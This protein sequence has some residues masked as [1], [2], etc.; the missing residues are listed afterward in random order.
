MVSAD[1]AYVERLIRSGALRGP[2][3]ELG[4]GYE[5]ETCRPLVQANG[6]LYYGT[7]VQRGP[8]VDFVA[9][10]ERPADMAVFDEVGPFGAILVL[11]VLEHTFD[12]IRVLDNA[13]TLLKP[14]GALVLLTPA[15]WPLHSFPFD[16]WRVLPDF[17][18]EYARRRGM[19]L[20]NEYFEY[21]GVGK[22]EEFRDKQGHPSFPPPSSQPWRL[23]FGRAVHRC[24]S[25]FGRSMFQ[26]SHIAVG[27]VLVAPDASPDARA[28]H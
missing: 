18:R 6:F 24:F 2:V 7:D 22:V 10:F 27:V 25:T 26:P 28:Q 3:L 20:L 11:N 1:L 9:D 16:S 21:V 14:G 15:V 5:G 19:R 4:T 13:A 12:P 23:L 8:H 17:Y